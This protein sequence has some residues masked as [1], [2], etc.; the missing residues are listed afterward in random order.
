MK[1][2]IKLA[3]ILFLITSISAGILGFS[4]KITEPLIAQADVIKKMKRQKK[5]Y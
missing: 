3:L 2:T 1:E 4:N 5:Y